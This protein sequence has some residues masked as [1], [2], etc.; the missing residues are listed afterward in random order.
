[1]IMTTEEYSSLV[2]EKRNGFFDTPF[3]LAYKTF[4]D[5]K[6]D[7]KSSDYFHKNASLFV[8]EMRTKCWA[9]YRTVE[10]KFMSSV[11]CELID[12]DTVATMDPVTAIENFV[13]EYPDHLYNLALSNTQ[14]RR[15]RA[16]KE[17]EAIIELMLIACDV[18]A[19]TQGTIGKKGF[20]ENNI[21]KLVD[22]IS[23]GVIQFLID[24]RDTTLISAKTSLRER[25]QEVPEEV[26]RTGINEMYLVTLDDSISQ[27]TLRILYEANIIVVTTQKIKANSYSNNQRVKSFEQLISIANEK[28]KN[29]DNYAYSEAE[30][31]DLKKYISTQI[32]KHENHPYV[33]KYYQIRLQKLL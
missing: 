24:K 28:A 30:I 18:P 19:D 31:I 25:W 4:I 20:T 12:K 5:L 7:Q 33:K 10:K 1:M 29:W 8:E 13:S 11:L 23:P 6:Y 32:K 2:K 26:S 17:F 14:A 15:S 3:D 21:G 22:F 16:G 27:E 9:E